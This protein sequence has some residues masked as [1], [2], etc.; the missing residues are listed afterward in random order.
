LFQD[1]YP[2]WASWVSLHNNDRQLLGGMTVHPMKL[3]TIAVAQ[4]CQLFDL[5]HED[6]Q[7]ILFI[8]NIMYSKVINDYKQTKPPASIIDN[9]RKLK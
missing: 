8:E 9:A 3:S 4:F 2:A 5:Y 6:M 1:N 7:K